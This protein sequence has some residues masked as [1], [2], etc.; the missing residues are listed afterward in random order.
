MGVS[1]VNELLQNTNP[2]Y[3][4]VYT[5]VYRKEDGL[6]LHNLDDPVL[7][8]LR[9]GVVAGT[10][11]A[12]LM[13]KYGLMD[14]VRSYQRTVD[15]RLYS[16]ATRAVEDVAKGVIDVAVIWGPIAGYT[17]KQ[18]KIPLTVTPL[19]AKVDA[20][21]LAFNVSMGLRR[22]ET[23]WKHQLNQQL[24][25]LA[26]SIEKILLEYDVPLLDANDRLIKP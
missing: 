26:P 4:S 18:Q 21:P 17:A 5:L 22:R 14:R 9:L 10:P 12:T 25:K 24:Q 16:P 8:D 7:K 23:T 1:S 20:V 2:Y 13:S 11:P 19:P 15:T 3:R 6:N